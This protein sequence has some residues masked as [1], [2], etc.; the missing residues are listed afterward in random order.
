M[1]LP[2]YAWRKQLLRWSLRVLRGLL[3]LLPLHRSQSS[4]DS[5][6]V[7]GHIWLDPETVCYL[8]YYNPN[9]ACYAGPVPT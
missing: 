3:L 7:F 5:G 2:S 1:A 4:S 6:G 9:R 8:D